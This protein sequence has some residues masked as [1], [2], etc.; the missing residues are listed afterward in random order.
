VS[1]AK[2]KVYGGTVML[3]IGKRRQARAII[4]TTSQ[5]NVAKAFGITLGDVRGFWSVTGNPAE[6]EAATRRYG[7]PLVAPLG[8]PNTAA[9]YVSLTEAKAARSPA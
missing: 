1:A 3:S 6:V 5:Q 4:A 2:A 7:V 9:D 8:Q